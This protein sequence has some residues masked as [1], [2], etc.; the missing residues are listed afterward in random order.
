MYSFGTFI[1]AGFAVLL[2]IEY[3]APA[4]ATLATRDMLQ[5]DSY[6]SV[7][8]NRSAKSDRIETDR[9][10]AAQQSAPAKQQPE[11][12]RVRGKIMVGCDAAFSNLSAHAR[13]NYASRCLV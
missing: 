5:P 7:T 2:A 8:V 1:A 10:P 13:L 11:A 6:Y 3:T 9:L 12:A 4:G